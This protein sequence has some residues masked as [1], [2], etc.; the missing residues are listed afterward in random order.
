M[1]ASN[2][3]SR[4]A[5]VE[6][7]APVEFGTSDISLGQPPKTPGNQEEED[8]SRVP[9]PQ[10]PKKSPEGSA[11][12]A[13]TEGVFSAKTVDSLYFQDSHMVTPRS[14]SRADRLSRSRCSTEHFH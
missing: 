11:D 8:P 14:T 5:Q 10:T 1:D 6:E 7:E 12:R 13:T 2:R 3:R 9:L 4:P